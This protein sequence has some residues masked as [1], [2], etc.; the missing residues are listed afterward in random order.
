M[1]QL[2]ERDGQRMLVLPG[3]PLHP[4]PAVDPPVETRFVHVAGRWRPERSH[5]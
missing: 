2:V 4:E 3:D 5:A 1:P